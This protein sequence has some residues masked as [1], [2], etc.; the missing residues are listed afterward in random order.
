MSD[1]WIV[2]LALAVTTAMV[3]ASGPVLMGERDLH[4]RLAGVV[5]LLAPALLT[6]L[7]VVEVF[8]SEDHIEV[9]ASLA[10]VAAAGGVLVWKRDALLPAIF[11]AAL[12]TA[13]LRAVG[14]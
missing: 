13:G 5:D 4:P 10:G 1:A 14:V 12:V 2:I 7:I 8:G 11:V 6:A 9:D 3:R